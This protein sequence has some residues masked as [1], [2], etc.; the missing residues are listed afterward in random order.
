MAD[1]PD[2]TPQAVA[3][4]VAEA[5]RGRAKPFSFHDYIVSILVALGLTVFYGGYYWLQRTYFF[6]APPNVDALYVP[7]KVVAVVGMVLL[8]FTFLIGPL[9]RYFNAFDYLMQYRKEIGIVGGF[10]ALIHPLLAYFFLP[11]KF[12]PSEIPLTS[13]TYGTA[14][15]GS[16]VAIF[17]IF[18]SFQSA[19]IMLGANRWWFLHRW[20]L[21]L[22]ILFAVI[23][24]FGIEWTTWMKWLTQSAGKPS[25]ELLYPW[26]P[27]PTAFAGL[28]VVWVVVVRLY[29]TVFLY[30]DLGLKPKDIVP[31]ATLRFRGRRFCIYSFAVLVAGNIYVLGRWMYYFSTR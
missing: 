13:L 30:R 8:A 12:P 28:F 31:D 14:V 7:D 19:I 9:Y 2:V 4:P 11:L 15:F 18:I 25:A 6:N 5:K 17:L 24:F 20:G 22:L 10:F 23:H 29:E 21:R 26:I 16:F 1:N 3:P 27:E